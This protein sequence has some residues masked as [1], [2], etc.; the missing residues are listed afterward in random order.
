[1]LSGVGHQPRVVTNV[2]SEPY[3]GVAEIGNERALCLQL[4]VMI[5]EEWSAEADDLENR[6][7]RQDALPAGVEVPIV[8]AYAAH[9]QGEK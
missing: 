5:D 9:D 4:L 8:A 3:T 2:D 1:M 6:R 7:L